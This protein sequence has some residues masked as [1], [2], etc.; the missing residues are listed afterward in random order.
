MSKLLQV[1][2]ILQCYQYRWDSTYTTGTTHFPSLDSWFPEPL[3]GSKRFTQSIWSLMWPIYLLFNKILKTED[4]RELKAENL[5]VIDPYLFQQ[6]SSNIDSHPHSLR[7]SLFIEVST[8]DLWSKFC[9]LHII[10]QIFFHWLY[11]NKVY[12]NH[13]CRY[14]TL[15]KYIHGIVALLVSWWFWKVL[16]STTAIFKHWLNYA[17]QIGLFL[18]NN[19]EIVVTMLYGMLEDPRWYTQDLVQCN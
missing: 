11:C 12:P 7:R 1:G 17:A 18:Y 15:T 6:S 13:A 16:V 19:I 14:H 9:S 8:C 10:L 3:V 2:H 5:S 4:E